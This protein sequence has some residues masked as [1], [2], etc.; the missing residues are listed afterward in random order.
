M[1]GIIPNSG[2]CK[3]LTSLECWCKV[4]QKE[5]DLS[6]TRCPQL[7]G[8]STTRTMQ[9]MVDRMNELGV[10]SKRLGRVIACSPQLLIRTP[11]E[12]NE[13]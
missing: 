2:L 10:K 1:R 4:P 7:V 13:V 8:C 3:S 5:V 9:P 6:I 11:E 12:F